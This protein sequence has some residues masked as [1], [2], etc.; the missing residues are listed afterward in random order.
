MLWAHRRRSVGI[1]ARGSE[2]LEASMG[3]A[4]RSKSLCTVCSGPD[5]GIL[6]LSMGLLQVVLAT[7][8][9]PSGDD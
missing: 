3:E 9:L 8:L 7:A 4:P 5:F 1:D 2:D 6:I